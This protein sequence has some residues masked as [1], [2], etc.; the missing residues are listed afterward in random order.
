MKALKRTIAALM[1]LVIVGGAAPVIHGGFTA[2]KPVTASAEEGYVTFD[3]STG[4][5]IL[6]GAVTKEQVQEYA[7]DLKVKKVYAEP[8]T[9][10]PAKS[11][12]LFSDFQ[13]V[14]E[15]DLSNADTSNVVTMNGMFCQC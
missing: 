4:T 8:G 2:L 7:L 13:A 3:K 10:L 11:S 9:V 15:I 6:S 1:S 14:T 12:L 5:L